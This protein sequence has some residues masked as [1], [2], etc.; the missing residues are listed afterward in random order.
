M[1][2][3][4]ADGAR[5]RQR[6]R[7]LVVAACVVVLLVAGVIIANNNG[8]DDGERSSVTSSSTTPPVPVTTTTI[9][10][11]T[12]GTSTPT[13]G[14]ALTTVPPVRPSTTTAAGTAG[15]IRLGTWGGQGIQLIVNAGGGSLEYDCA[16]G[17]IL[18][19]L[20]AS[21][22]GSFE[23]GGTHTIQRG[24]PPDPARVPRAAPARYSGRTDGTQMQLTVTLPE[25][26]AQLGPF[27]LG[28]GQQALLSR[29][30]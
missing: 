14:G 1:I 12:L 30:G 10:G 27:T 4:G 19:P 6:N 11:T 25:T 9:G 15:P 21:A 7:L 22:G 5:F 16:V 28:L 2:E 8:S 29:C 13:T 20:V 23:A 3:R 26:G 18:E 24:G 17:L